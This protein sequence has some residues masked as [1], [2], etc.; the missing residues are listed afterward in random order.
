LGD[1][2]RLTEVF[3]NLVNNAID[4]MP[5]GGTLAIRAFPNGFPEGG[6]RVEVTDTGRG[7]PQDD[8]LRIFDPFFTTKEP[9][10]GTGL[11]LS[12]SHGIIKDHGGQIW[13]SSQ[14]GV[15]T[16]LVVTLP[17]EAD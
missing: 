3:V 17:K 16:T 12:I 13:A 15:G 14:P 4:A 9:G 5:E 7:I 6:V 1:S 8:V 10:R 11:G 2:G